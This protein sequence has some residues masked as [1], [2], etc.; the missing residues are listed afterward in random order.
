MAIRDSSVR[1]IQSLCP[2]LS[3]SIAGVLNRMLD[4]ELSY[5]PRNM[6]EVAV[7]FESYAAGDAVPKKQKCNKPAGVRRV[8]WNGSLSWRRPER[9]VV[10]SAAQQVVDLEYVQEN[11][12]NFLSECVSDKNHIVW[13]NEY[14][15]R[16]IFE[17]TIEV[18]LHRD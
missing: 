15:L 10:H 2:D 17:C 8:C 9:S 13:L 3:L 11:V 14:P 6:M 7:A 16:R 12:A 1:E 4:R 18:D 5:R